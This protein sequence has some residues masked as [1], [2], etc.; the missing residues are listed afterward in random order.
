MDY[1]VYLL[2][3]TQSNCT[4]VGITNHP[5]RRLRMHN[6][7]L[8]GGARYTTMRKGTGEWMYYGC[9][10]GVDKSTALSIERKIHNRRGKGKTPLEKRKDVIQQIL[11]E[12]NLS[13]L[14]FV[15][16]EEDV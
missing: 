14:E 12:P 13:H 2:Y 3:H 5:E 8:K 6:G 16:F 1:I 10:L 11:Q 15:V 7:E 4:Y 9:I